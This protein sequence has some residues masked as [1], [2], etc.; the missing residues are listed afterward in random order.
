MI[1]FTSSTSFLII[2]VGV[3]RDLAIKPRSVGLLICEL[4]AYRVGRVGIENKS[5]IVESD[6][7]V[8]SSAP[9]L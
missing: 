1:F 8:F 5:D 7:F 2:F 6:S 9:G 3:V 4:H